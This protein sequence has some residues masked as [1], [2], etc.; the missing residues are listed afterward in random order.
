GYVRTTC[1]SGWTSLTSQPEPSATQ[2]MSNKEAAEPL[3]LSRDDKVV[4]A[5]GP[6]A[7][8]GAQGPP[9]HAGDQGPPAHA[10][11]QGP[12]AHAGDQGPPAHAGGSD[13]SQRWQQ[14]EE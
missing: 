10:G 5:Q 3:V 1:V 12:P 7:H 2:S 14:L 9:A 8:A 11:D 6:P 4:G 13:T